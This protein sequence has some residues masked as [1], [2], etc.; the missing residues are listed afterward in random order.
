MPSDEGQR[1]LLFVDLETSHCGCGRPRGPSRGPAKNGVAVAEP[2]AQ[3]TSILMDSY[4]DNFPSAPNLPLQ[5]AAM[6][7]LENH[8][9]NGEVVVPKGTVL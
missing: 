7:M 6:D 4:R 8:V 1:F 5:P 9:V 3:P 2:Y